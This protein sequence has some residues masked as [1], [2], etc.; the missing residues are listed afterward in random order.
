VIERLAAR[1]YRSRRLVVVAWIV[2]LAGLNVLGGAFAGETS[3]D[4]SLPDSE[5]Q[6]ALEVL[7]AA[8][9]A[10]Q[11]G[12]QAQIVFADPGG[13]GRDRARITALLD[14]VRAGV[15][16]VEVTGPFDPGG[17][18]LVAPDG[19]VAYATVGL[20]E[21][22][23]DR[24]AADAARIEALRDTTAGGTLQVELGG[25]MFAAETSRDGA[26]QE[27]GPPAEAIGVLAAVVILLVAFGSVLAMGLPIVV[28]IFGAGCGMAAILLAANVVELPGFAGAAAAMVAIGVGIDYAL[29]VV[30]R[31]REAL[32]GGADPATAVGIAASTAG[33]SVLF[34]GITVV[35]AVLGLLTMGLGLINGVA[36]GIAASVLM[37]MLAALTLLPALLGFAGRNIDR[38]SLPWA[39]R[40]RDPGTT[41][42]ARWSRAVQRRPLPY[43]LGA[44][45]LLLA[46]AAPVTDLRLG[47][48]DA[49]LQ[50]AD[51]T[52]RRA[53]DLLSRGF[54]PGSNG[55]L[56]VAAEL[57]PGGLPAMTTLSERIRTTPGVASVSPPIPNQA[58]TAAI[59]QVIPTTAPRDEATN[60]LV[61]RLREDVV[62]Q[63]LDGTGVVASVGGVTAGAIDYADY[64][65]ERLPLFVGV[66]LA[67]SFVLLMLVFR[68]VLVPLKAVLMNLLSVL[69]TYG[70]LVAVFQWG[71]GVELLDLGAAAPVEA[72]VPMM[73]FAVVFGLSMDYEVFLLSRIKEEYDATGDNATAVAS[74]LART[75]RVITA[76]AAIMVCV[77]ASFVLGS[78]RE[79]KLFGFGLAFAVFIDATVVRLVLVP[80][81][82]ELLGRANWWLPRWLDRILPRVAVEG[83]AP[84]AA[85]AEAPLTTAGDRP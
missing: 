43:A 29:L 38:L 58:G 24:L 19:T 26:G 68:S 74:G 18:R 46:L 73:L 16:D 75:A 76:A 44:L 27:S 67:A 39:K 41:P 21:R 34:A 11:A 77:F 4:F 42:A 6:R 13:V 84:E 82:M 47:F 25:S 54:G 2:L 66:V 53:Y 52:A 78:E 37:T 33:R 7:A 64:T 60:D 72:W 31:Y 17:E 36:V 32:A 28:G 23:A 62:P 10:D 56:V 30:T 79:L 61:H 5:S 20:A 81:T 15:A 1:C 8:G 14:G 71:W 50:P 83:R 55:P 40:H 85:P 35:L 48:G 3:D 12:T 57:P 80:A 51:H 63:A 70:A 22:D 9:F 49:G 65:A 59:V 69:A 45:A